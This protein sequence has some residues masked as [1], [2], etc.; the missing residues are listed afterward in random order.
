MNMRTERLEPVGP[1]K[2]ESGRRGRQDII[3]GILRVAKHG[4][5]KT[6]IIDKV[7]LSSAQSTKYLE[8]L[9]AAGY[10]S[11]EGA[12]WKTTDKGLQ[13][14]GACETCHSLMNLT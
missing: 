6:N 1:L 10:I 13:V 5:K 12:I 3:M 7:K 14:I 2:C 9:K 11:E 8:G 4:S